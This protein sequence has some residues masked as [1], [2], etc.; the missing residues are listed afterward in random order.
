M[1]QLDALIGRW[2]EE[3]EWLNYRSALIASVIASGLSGK[4][5]QPKDFMPSK[6]KGQ[7]QTPDQMAQQL[8]IFNALMG[9]TETKNG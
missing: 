1:R 2:N 9:G 7:E 8:K 5:F 3:Q 4:E 6:E